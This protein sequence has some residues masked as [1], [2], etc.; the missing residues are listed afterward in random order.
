MKRNLLILTDE[1]PRWEGDT[2]VS[3]AVKGLAQSLS[4]YYKVYVLCPHCFC[5]AVHQDMDDITVIR[6][7]YF[8]PRKWQALSNEDGLLV[9]L[10]QNFFAK[11]I[12][13]FFCLFELIYLHKTIK[14]YN[15]YVINI[16]GVF[17]HAFLFGLIKSSVKIPSVLTESGEAVLALSNDDFIKKN[18]IKFAVKKVDLTIPVSIYSRYKLEKICGFSFNTKII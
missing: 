10:R 17:P 9:S 5:A 7:P 3:R 13:P 15:I 14:K 18:I 8:Y 11:L 2:A 4:R 16:H 6:F 12:F 1:F